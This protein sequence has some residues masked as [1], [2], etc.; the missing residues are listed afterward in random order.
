MRTAGLRPYRRSI[1]SVQAS[2]VCSCKSGSQSADSLSALKDPTQIRPRDRIGIERL[3][4]VVQPAVLLPRLF[5]K[6]S[7]GTLGSDRPVD[8]DE[9]DMHA[10]EAVLSCDGLAQRSKSMLARG[11]RAEGVSSTPS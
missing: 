7:E 6:Q 5:R 1:S 11:E 4:I 2:R 8:H 9:C 10:S 3:S